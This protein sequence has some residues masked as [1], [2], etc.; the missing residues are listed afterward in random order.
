LIKKNKSSKEGLTVE[1]LR[2]YPGFE[3]ISDGEAEHIIE[4]INKFCLLSFE[5]YE[6]K[7]K[8]SINK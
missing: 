6:T 4:Q 8:T 1:E 5:I 3:H 7:Q 2:A